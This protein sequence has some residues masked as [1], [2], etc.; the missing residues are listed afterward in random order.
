MLLTISIIVLLIILYVLYAQNVQATNPINVVD[1]IPNPLLIA[2]VV[3]AS[4][5]S[6]AILVFVDLNTLSYDISRLQTNAASCM[7][8]ESFNVFNNQLTSFVAAMNKL[9]NFI[10]TTTTPGDIYD[11][12][13]IY[14]SLINLMQPSLNILSNCAALNNINNFNTDFKKLCSDLKIL[15]S[16]TQYLANINM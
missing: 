13:F 3:L 7:S 8:S 12:T 14:T 1:N 11:I 15:C 5:Q 4:L 10:L 16:A 6:R 2:Q 9:M